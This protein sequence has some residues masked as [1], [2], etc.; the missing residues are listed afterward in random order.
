MILIVS[1]KNR[2]RIDK[3]YFTGVSEHDGGLYAAEYTGKI[4]VY[5]QV[6]EWK[7][8]RRIDLGLKMQEITLSIQDVM[9]YVCLCRDSKLVTYSL[10]GIK[11]GSWGSEG[12]EEAGD[13]DE[14]DLCIVGTGGAALVAD[15]RSYR[16]QVLSAD[17]QWSVVSLQP[18][19]RMPMSALLYRDRLLVASEKD[20]TL[21]VY[22][23]SG[24][25]H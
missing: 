22:K 21:N 2:C 12:C 10:S 14:P 4:H 19:V 23:T 15:T 8:C 13:L 17:R 20:N 25:D 7:E 24:D 3:G 6:G 9:I 18:P 16:L 1:G 5:E 11:L